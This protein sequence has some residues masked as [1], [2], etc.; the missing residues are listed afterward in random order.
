M[1]WCRSRLLSP[2]KLQTLHLKFFSLLWRNKW[3][4]SWWFFSKDFPQIVQAIDF[5]AL[6]VCMWRAKLPPRMDFEHKLQ[7]FL[8]SCFVIF[9]LVLRID[10]DSVDDTYMPTLSLFI[11][12]KVKLCSCSSHK[13]AKLDQFC[14]FC[15]CLNL[16]SEGGPLSSWWYIEANGQFL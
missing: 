4:F 16:Y 10:W 12:L 5:S 6:W 7:D 13:R 11:S 14:F 9:L 15:E 2:E 1:W 8:L 3:S